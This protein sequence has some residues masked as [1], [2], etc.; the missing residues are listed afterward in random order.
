MKTCPYCAEEIQDAAIK[1]RYCLSTIGDLSAA[2]LPSVG[3][4]LL[5]AVTEE[6]LDF[7]EVVY[8][9]FMERDISRRDVRQFI[10]LGLQAT[11][12]KYKRLLERI[13]LPTRD[14]QK[15][16]DFLRQHDLKPEKVHTDPD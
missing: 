10:S 15:F 9:P 4:E 14:Y 1:C 2:A 6:G 12:G 5:R 3:E 16:M 13:G 7:W 11:G 8:R